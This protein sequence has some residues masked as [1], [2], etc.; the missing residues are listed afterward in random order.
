METTASFHIKPGTSPERADFYAR[1][2]K[3][4]TAPLWE[5]LGRLITPEPQ[6]QSQPYLWK[7]DELQPLASACQAAAP[8]R[9]TR[10]LKLPPQQGDDGGTD[11]AGLPASR[12]VPSCPGDPRCPSGT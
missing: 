10:G 8:T 12:G 5:V 3:K 4:N 2:D 7:Y 6:P 11:A 9:K 1:L